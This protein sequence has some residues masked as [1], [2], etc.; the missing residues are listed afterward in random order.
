MIELKMLSIEFAQPKM[1]M[2]DEYLSY[3]TT[4]SSDLIK[5]QYI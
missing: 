1:M 5:T 4:F 2:N 3:L